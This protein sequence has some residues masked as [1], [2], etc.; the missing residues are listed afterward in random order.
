MTARGSEPITQAQSCTHYTFFHH[1]VF[2]K[3]ISLKHLKQNDSVKSEADYW[4]FLNVEHHFVFD[5][6]DPYWHFKDLQIRKYHGEICN[7]ATFELYVRPVLS[8]EKL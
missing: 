8:N 2:T 3:S 1:R 4:A 6:S 7:V 5:A